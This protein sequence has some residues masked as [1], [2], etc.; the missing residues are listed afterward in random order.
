MSDTNYTTLGYVEEV[1]FGTTPSANLQTLR[2]TGGSIT[3]RRTTVT[4]E[5]IRS[6][7]RS[8]KPVRTAEWFAGDIQ[9]EWSY[10]TLNDIME[11]ML[12]E[13]FDSTVLV[14][15]TTKKSYT[16][17]QQ[18][19]DPDFSPSQYL[20]YKGG[21]IG[22]LSMSLALGAIVGGSFSVL[23]ATPSIAQASAGTG[24]TAATTTGPLNTV[25]MVTTIQ[26]N[27]TALS[28]VTGLDINI[29]RD[30][31][32]K[33]EIGALNP[34]EIGVGRLL[35]TGTIQQYFTD[36]TLM[37]AWF[38]FGDRDIALVFTDDASNTLNV[39]IPKMKL[40]GDPNVE[41]SGPDSDVIASYN[42]EAYADVGDAA[43]IQITN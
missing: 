31:R 15:G 38:A 39:D 27:S 33:H 14:D 12:M 21:R 41:I 17:E 2:R 20:I 24:D 19:E 23:G 1:T 29:N 16:F 36:D 7:L 3:P 22:A 35:V 5:E 13:S 10:T 25:N 32:A 43:L 11:G 4:S 30:L 26:E 37:D 34:F 40:V 18:F 6:D 9:V 8:G 42:F 28:K